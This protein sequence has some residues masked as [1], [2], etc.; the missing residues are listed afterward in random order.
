[1]AINLLKPT[2]YVMHQQIKIQK[3][4]RSTHIV[5]M[6]FVSVHL[7]IPNTWRSL[8]TSSLH[9]FLGLLLR[10]VPSSSWV[11]VLLGILSSSILSRWPN[12]LVLCPFICFTIR[13]IFSSTCVVYLSRNIKKF[14]GTVCFLFFVNI[15]QLHARKMCNIKFA[16]KY[17]K[18]GFYKQWIFTCFFQTRHLQGCEVLPLDTLTP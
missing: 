8:S 15:L 6:C 16:H 13:V 3:T 10:L 12:Q 11:K 17:I 4:L 2:G 7:L 1:V 5:F 18:F 9:P 14:C